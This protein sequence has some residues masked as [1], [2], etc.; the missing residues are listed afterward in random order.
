MFFEDCGGFVL[1]YLPCDYF[2]A[3]KEGK[4]EMGVQRNDKH[5]IY[6]WRDEQGQE[7]CGKNQMLYKK[8]P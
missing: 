5:S 1:I 7:T 3:K 6:C 4:A 2:L 8:S